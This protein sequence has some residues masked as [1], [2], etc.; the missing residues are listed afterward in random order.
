MEQIAVYKGMVYKLDRPIILDRDVSTDM[1]L[2]SMY[3]GLRE[4]LKQ[5]MKQPSRENGIGQKSDY[6]VVFELYGDNVL[7]A[8]QKKM[9]DWSKLQVVPAKK[10]SEFMTQR[11][12]DF[13]SGAR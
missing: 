4:G 5:Y 7:E 2:A 3:K 13:Y 6:A 9:V 11:S 8:L 12:S 1:P 10:Y